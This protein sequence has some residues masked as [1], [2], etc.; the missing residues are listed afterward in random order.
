M[1]NASPTPAWIQMF[2]KMNC[3]QLCKK[4]IWIVKS[5]FCESTL[6]LSVH[7]YPDIIFSTGFLL[8]MLFRK[9]HA[10]LWVAAWYFTVLLL[11]ALCRTSVDLALKMVTHFSLKLLC[12]IY[13]S[14][15]CISCK[16]LILI[17]RGIWFQMGANTQPEVFQVFS[18][19]SCVPK[20]AF[21]NFRRQCRCWS[22]LQFGT[23]CIRKSKIQKTRH[24]FPECCV[25]FSCSVICS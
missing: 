19:F 5:V 16:R 6:A 12:N 2:L 8:R 1:M 13:C 23:A 14:A 24:R 17:V 15:T 7:I 4:N 22:H 20:A 10:K 11:E 18:V 3:S 9:S 25:C 21:I